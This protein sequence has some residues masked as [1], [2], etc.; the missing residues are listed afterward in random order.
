MPRVPLER[1]NSETNETQMSLCLQI[2]ACCELSRAWNRATRERRE[3]GSFSALE[4]TKQ[5][6]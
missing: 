5:V 2:D 6:P 4:T 1:V 3:N